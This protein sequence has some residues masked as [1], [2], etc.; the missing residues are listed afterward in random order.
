M[1]G[2]WIKF[3]ENTPDKPEVYG[4]AEMLGIDAD[5]VVGKLIR[6]WSWASR[7]CHADGV[8]NVTALS[9]ICRVAGVPNFGQA[10]QKVGWLSINGD[11]IEFPNFDRHCT[12]TAKERALATKRKRNQRG[13]ESRNCHAPNVTKTGLEKRR[14]EKSINTPLA[15]LE[16]PQN[17]FARPTLQQA[18]S[19]GQ[20]IGITTAAVSVWWHKREASEWM[21][22]TAGGGTT[23]VGQNWQAD[24]TASK[25]WAEDEAKK[26][27][28]TKPQRQFID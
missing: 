13:K 18:I 19:A 23:R 4:M 21:K 3:E 1:A 15:P 16:N 7:N 14:E 20:S 25:S 5:A 27:P 24:L 6:V 17:G 8:T 11:R 28:A 22:G 12:Q 2:D 10:M 9:A 26:A